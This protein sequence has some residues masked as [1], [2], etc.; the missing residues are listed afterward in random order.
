M[1][2]LPISSRAG[3]KAVSPYRVGPPTVP[4]DTTVGDLP[5]HSS[6]P[7]SL[8]S[9]SV[10]HRNLGLHL[11]HLLKIVHSLCDKSK[12][13][14]ASVGLDIKHNSTWLERFTPPQAKCNKSIF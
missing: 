11:P 1:N 2:W 12:P 3:G 10:S 14:T 7:L 5:I 8:V 13:L 6:N 4:S 9:A